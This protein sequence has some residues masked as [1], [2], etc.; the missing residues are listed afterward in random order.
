VSEVL[1]ECV[2][3]D[4]LFVTQ[5]SRDRKHMR[6]FY[7]Y[8]ANRQEQW[9]IRWWEIKDYMRE[10]LKKK[11]P[12][13][14]DPIK[15][16]EKWSDIRN[17]QDLDF[18]RVRHLRSAI[19]VPVCAGDE[20]TSE[21]YL[22]RTGEGSFDERE[23]DLLASLPIAEAL[24]HAMHLEHE[25]HTTF[26]QDLIGRLTKEADNG[27]RHI[28]QVTV[29]ELA[30]HF[31]WP[32]VSILRPEERESVTGLRLFAQNAD[33]KAPYRDT[34]WQPV[35][36]GMLGEAYRE[37]R[38]LVA[39]DVSLPEWRGRYKME[40]GSTQSEL[41][42]PVADDR[43][44][45]VVN[46]EDSQ[47]NA[48]AD[49]EI[50]AVNS[51]LSEVRVHVQRAALIAHWKAAFEAVNDALLITDTRGTI[52]LT[53]PACKGL[54]GKPE[55]ELDGRSIA[56]LFAEPAFGEA[57]AAAE[58]V[59][60][61]ECEVK[62]AKGSKP[63]LV[64]CRTLSEFP[65]KVYAIADLTVHKEVEKIG[66]LKDLFYEIARQTKV[67]LSIAATIVQRARTAEEGDVRVML[68]TVL[69]YLRKVDLTFDR[70]LFYER[71]PAEE[72]LKCESVDMQD[73]VE[74]V[75]QRMPETDVRRI[76]RATGRERH[77]KIVGDSLRLAFCVESLLSYLLRVAPQ[78]S[79]IGVTL[80]HEGA[81]L[82]VQL[83]IAGMTSVPVELQNPSRADW[84]SV[85]WF[86]LA[87]GLAAVQR[88]AARQEG[89]VLGPGL[90]DGEWGF[91]ME[92]KIA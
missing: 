62:T 43:F 73:V 48:F 30:R 46:V 7:Y 19:R 87:S 83:V 49:R 91:R 2:P 8:D 45:W 77:P 17:E 82:A 61:T 59:D 75:L 12:H 29:D 36:E 69:P 56:S 53:N 58:T 24:S 90:W 27:L 51:I 11:I 14:Y 26:L 4:C 66:A 41:C 39:G 84:L 71:D 89:Q 42:C 21:L 22:L 16:I 86:E 20:V 44:F 38:M 74:A 47:R 31:N 72:Q 18:L 10:F 55:E 68:G 80:K 25:R 28:A 33:G 54:F 78:E 34:F 52:K 92:L 32:H 67:P 3:Y 64:T 88:L 81:V 15:L 57:A 37:R 79:E 1:L 63:V 50:E 85:A 70:M 6:Q 60:K 65:E 35:S 76:T 40:S 23:R 13:I 5:Y 9:Q